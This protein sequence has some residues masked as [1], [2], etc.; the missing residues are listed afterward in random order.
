MGGRRTSEDAPSNPSTKSDVVIVLPPPE[1]SERTSADGS[2]T[3][4]SS[5]EWTQVIGGGTLPTTPT[6]PTTPQTYDSSAEDF[7]LVI[8]GDPHRGVEFARPIAISEQDL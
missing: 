2:W 8:P 5:P 1:S 6:T 3:E 7:S 4:P